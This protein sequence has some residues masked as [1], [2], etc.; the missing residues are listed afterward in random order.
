[1]K[2]AKKLALT[3]ALTLALAALAASLAACNTTRGFG[4]DIEKAGEGLKG[5]A[6][7]NG[8]D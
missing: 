8:A 5:S 3:L 4:E 7:R 1:M 6:E 2:L